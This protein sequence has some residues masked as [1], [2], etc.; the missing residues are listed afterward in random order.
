MNWV[1]VSTGN[2]RFPIKDLPAGRQ[3]SGMTDKETEFID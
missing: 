1:P 3:V 2:P